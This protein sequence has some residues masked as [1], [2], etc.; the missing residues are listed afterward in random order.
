MPEDE[1]WSDVWEGFGHEEV[2]VVGE[3]FVGF[4]L[5]F[6]AGETKSPHARSNHLGLILQLIQ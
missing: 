3:V 1:V 5:V 6:V 2:H 4:Y